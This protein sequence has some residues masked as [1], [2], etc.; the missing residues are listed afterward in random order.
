MQ[1]KWNDIHFST[2]LVILPLYKNNH[3]IICE[4]KWLAP[5][6]PYM[7][8]PY[9]LMTL[10]L[11]SQQRGWDAAILFSHPHHHNHLSLYPSSGHLCVP[12]PNLNLVDMYPALGIR[13]LY[14]AGEMTLHTKE[15]SGLDVHV[16]NELFFQEW[17]MPGASISWV[18]TQRSV[19]GTVVVP[20]DWVLC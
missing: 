18:P 16:S 11:S 14:I 7:S 13:W 17:Y 4:H 2:P 19:L 8:L 5:P 15:R 9:K 1:M 6:T 10:V 12:E 20:I 3:L